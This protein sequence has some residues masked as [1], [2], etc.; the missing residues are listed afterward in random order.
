MK[1][2]VEDRKALQDVMDMLSGVLQQASLEVP[3][4]IGQLLHL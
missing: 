2:T 1:L 3:E 4:R